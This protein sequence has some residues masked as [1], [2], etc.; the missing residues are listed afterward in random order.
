VQG[1]DAVD[2]LVRAL[3]IVNRLGPAAVDCCIVARGGGA[4]DDLMAFNAEAVCRAVAA[5]AVPTIAAVGHETDVTLTDLVADVRAATPSMAAELALPDRADVARHVGA[6]GNRLANGLTRRTGVLAERLAR[7]ADRLKGNL[8]ALRAERARRLDRL[9][10]SLD[11]L[12]P[13]AVLGRGYRLARTLDGR[14]ARRRA[15]L[16]PGTAFILRVADGDVNAE[17][18]S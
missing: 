4:R 12:S 6:L 14:V 16:P 9:A 5:S 2:E 1:E 15:D 8:A 3:E 10:A 7:G 17:A 18:R 11:A 13:L